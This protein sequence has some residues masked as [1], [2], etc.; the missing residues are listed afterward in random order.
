MAGGNA[1]L[2]HGIGDRPTM[3]VNLATTAE[4]GVRTVMEAVARALKAAGFHVERVDQF[5]DAAD[6]PGWPGEMAEGWVEWTV[7]RGGQQVI[8]QM[9]FTEAARAPVTMDFGPVMAL[10]DVLGA[11]VVALVERSE[12]RDYVDVGAAL[13]RFDAHQLM[14]WAVALE[15]SLTLENFAAVAWQLDAMSD[16]EFARYLDVEGVARLRERFSAW[17]RQGGA[18]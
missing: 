7:A 9:N 5:A 2:A 11:K 1:L 18:S 3:D 10:E 15:P 8:L 16:D 6:I 4:D 14:A 13:A 17:P 12:D